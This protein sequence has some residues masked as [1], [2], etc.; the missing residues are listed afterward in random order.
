MFRQ[1]YFLGELVFFLELAALFIFEADF[2]T[3]ALGFPSFARDDLIL[4]ALFL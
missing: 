3:V 2:R 4:A 1:P